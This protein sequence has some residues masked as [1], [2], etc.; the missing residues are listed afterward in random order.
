M[1]APA[2]AA[3]RRCAARP[4]PCTPKHTMLSLEFLCR[5]H[6]IRI[7]QYRTQRA[8][9]VYNTTC[10]ERNGGA[11]PRPGPVSPMPLSRILGDCFCRRGL[12]TCAARGQGP[13]RQIAPTMVRRNGGAPP[14]PGPVRRIQH[15]VSWIYPQ[16]SSRRIPPQLRP[17]HRSTLVNHK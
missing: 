1:T 7:P 3:K 8:H 11:P 2:A 4:A 15:C 5:R 10:L 6:Q 13:L 12:T 16:I 14:R 9:L 17:I